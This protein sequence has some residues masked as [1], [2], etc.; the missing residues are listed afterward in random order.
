MSSNDRLILLGKKS[1]LEKLKVKIEIKLKNYSDSLR[2]NCSTL[3]I[4][5]LEEMDEKAIRYFQMSWLNKL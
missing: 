4:D 5:N 1:D 2:Q 3:L